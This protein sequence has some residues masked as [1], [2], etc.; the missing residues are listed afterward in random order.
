MFQVTQNAACNHFHGIQE[1]LARWLL[2]VRERVPSSDFYLTQEYL[3]GM[4]GTR[5]ESVTAAAHALK[6]RNLIKYCRANI[7]IL[8]QRGLKA[9][10]CSCY[11]PVKRAGL[12]A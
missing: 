8:D 6:R 1:R 10:S 3:A 11:R 7:T 9:A 2:M 4:L 5:R 12:N